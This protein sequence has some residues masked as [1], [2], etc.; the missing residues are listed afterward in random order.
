GPLPAK[1]AT[2]TSD[3]AGVTFQADQP[4][5][6]VG[7]HV[8]AVPVKPQVQI[9]TQA[10]RH[11]DAVQVTAFVHCTVPVGELHT[12][13]L[14]A[15]DWQG[16]DPQLEATRTKD[17]TKQVHG[18]G[19]LTW[20]LTFLPGTTQQYTLKLVGRFPLPPNG[21][22]PMPALDVPDAEV[23]HSWLAVVGPQLQA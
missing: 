11:E 20:K 22:L 4:D 21:P 12:L 9:L 8:E 15:R 18:A 23:V 5:H 6:A 19:D 17:I 13:T 10:E 1:N 16:G 7:V 3:A 14:L 2:A